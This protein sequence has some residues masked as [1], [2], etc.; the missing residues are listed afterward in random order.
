MTK[1][2]IIE[3]L[4]ATFTE[5]EKTIDGFSEK[6]FFQRP[7][8]DKWSAAENIQHL[9]LSV[10]PLVSL[11]GKK[12]FMM[13]QWGKAS[14][15]SRSYNEIMTFYM[16]KLAQTPNI[17]SPITTPKELAATKEEEMQNFASI[18]AKFLERAADL[19][20]DDLDL[21]QIP[22]PLLGLLT[23]REFLYFT[24]YHTIHHHHAIKAMS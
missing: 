24:D 15:P 7:P 22:H 5:L 2:K 10:K 23:I 19:S 4:K 16:D 21:Y 1:L 18:N 9:F 13:E 8:S 11:F 12:D 20:E 14:H 3:K 17:F 6:L